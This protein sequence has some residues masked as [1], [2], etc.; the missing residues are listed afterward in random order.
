[1]V[2]P[3]PRRIARVLPAAP[4]RVLV[5]M[6]L[7]TAL[8][9]VVEAADEVTGD[10]LQRNGIVPRMLDGLDGVLW[11]PFLHDTWAHLAANTLPFLLFG[12]LVMAGGLGQ[13]IAV[14]ATIWVLG[15]LGV[16]LLGP[17]GTN[18]IGASGLIFGWLA[19]LLVRGFYAR[20]PGQVALAV[21]LFL[22]WGGMLFGV[23]PGQPGVSWQGHL[24]GAL[25]GVFAARLVVRADRR[26]ATPEVHA[27]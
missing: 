13:F 20:S 9:Y 14:T 1:M 7:F 4:L 24:F 15:G 18:H 22:F 11:A 25:A 10:Q 2:S 3:P 5:G 27:P 12:F 21:V 16:W 26:S 19:F 8:L 17:E 23:L 6:T